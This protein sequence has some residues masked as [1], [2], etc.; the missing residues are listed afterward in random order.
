MLLLGLLGDPVA[1]SLS[2]VMHGAALRE[3]GIPGVYLPLRVLAGDLEVALAGLRVLGWG[4][5]NVTIPHKQGVMR[6]LTRLDPPA[7]AIGAVNTLYPLEGGWGGTNT[8]GL[9]FQA[10]L[11]HEKWQG[12]S[13]TILG[14]GGSARAVIWG[15]RN[16]GMEPIRVIVR[17]PGQGQ[18]VQEQFGGIG[19]GSWADLA[20]VLPGTDLLV[21]TT[22]V[23]MKDPEQ[24]PVARDVLGLLPGWAW[25]YDLIYVPAPTRLLREAQALGYRTQD[26]LEMLVQQGAAALSLWLGGMPVPVEVMR[27][28]AEQQLRR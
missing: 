25:V 28:A 21:N 2:P 9:G 8:D 26:G 11:K 15:C 5:L 12:R 22:P 19:V 7:Q 14:G 10:P 20:E 3:L 13:V 24:T 6:Y 4:G 17:D 1:H 18:L 16:L 23:G 27:Q